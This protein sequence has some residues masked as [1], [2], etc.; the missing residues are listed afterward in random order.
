MV[1]LSVGHE[2]YCFD[3]FVTLF[4]IS[5]SGEKNRIIAVTGSQR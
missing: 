2:A 4:E 3:V 5:W 1:L